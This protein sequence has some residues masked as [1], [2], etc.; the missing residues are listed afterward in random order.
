MGAYTCHWRDYSALPGPR[1]R[2]RYLLI[3]VHRAASPCTHVSG[4]CCGQVVGVALAGQMAAALADDRFVVQTHSK[5]TIAHYW[6]MCLRAMLG[7]VP[8]TLRSSRRSRLTV[9]L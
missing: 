6:S 1:G 8:A 9:C 4:P 5:P 3:A 7:P 2:F